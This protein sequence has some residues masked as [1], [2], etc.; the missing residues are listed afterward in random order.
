MRT[1]LKYSLF[2]LVMISFFSCEEDWLERQSQTILG[3]DQVMNDPNLI[4]GLLANYYDRLPADYNLRANS[5]G[6]NYAKMTLYDDAVWSNSTN[7]GEENRNTMPVY[8][9]NT[10]T[11]WDYSLVRDLNL[12]IEN[13]ETFGTKLTLAQ[14]AQFN[15][16]FRFLRAYHYFEMVKR[17]GGVPLITSQLLVGNDGNVD[18]L[19]KPRDKESAIYDFVASECD[20]IKDLIGNTGSN[21]RANKYAVLALKSR[22]MLHAAS[23]AKYNNLLTPSITLPGEVVGIP[24]SKA[25]GY[26]QQALDAAK[27]IIAGGAYSLY[28]GNPNK[29][30]NFYEAITKKQGNKEVILAQDYLQ[31]KGRTHQFSYRNI[32]FSLLEDVFEG[33]AVTPSLNLVE[34]FDYLDGSQGTLK[35]RTA[36]NSDFIY[37][38]NPQD[39]FANKD[40]R[41]YGTVLYP[42]VSFKGKDIA[43]QAGV[44]EWNATT[45]T[46]KV[47]EG[48]YGSVYTDGKTL[49]GQ[50]GP[51]RTGSMISCTGF[52][53]RKYID[54]T[55]G[56]ATIA[57][58]SD[59]WWVR[60]RMGEV[61]LNACEAA[62]ELNKLP[63]ALGYI[64]TLRQRAG[65]PANSLTALSLDKVLNERRCELAFEDNR[66]WDLIRTRTATTVWDGVSSNRNA[67]QRALYGYRVIRPGDAA[68]DGKYVYVELVAPRFKSAR[69]FRIQNYYSEVPQ[70]VRDANN[71]IIPN[72]FH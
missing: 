1:L 12:S 28:Q 31:S 4:A 27:E 32:A 63:E 24:A 29:G 16:E 38:N 60:F 36:D 35:T 48:A 20:A 72:P 10:W 47:F 45:S 37:Y 3:G 18:A 19:K 57:R 69:N 70:N 13:L 26:Y 33:S 61:Y 8:N 21:T 34:S 40:P 56:S 6:D 25:N 15:A 17:M 41:L 64:N 59:T 46:Y 14:K 49:T 68:R 50:G 62:F 71:L 53:L 54:S 43:L 65:F 2:C 11:L 67:M 52:Y 51:T 44:M 5:T 66:H 58:Q 39:I 7:T 55:P 42:G 30:E 9:T 23:V 22:A